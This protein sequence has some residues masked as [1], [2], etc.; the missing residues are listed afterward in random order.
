MESSISGSSRRT[1]LQRTAV[2]LGGAVG[3]AACGQAGTRQAA[4]AATRPPVAPV[5]GT[6]WML[7]GSGRTLVPA[8]VDGVVDPA[9]IAFGGELIDPATG[10]EVGR[11]R[12]QALGRAGFPGQLAGNFEI[13]SL[14]LAGDALYAVGPAGSDR[15]ERSYTVIGG[16]GR[17][18]GARGTCVVREAPGGGARRA[19]QF[20]IS[21]S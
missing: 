13:Q 9:A 1:L 17:F 5:A 10:A 11:F 16:T 19:L 20:D 12:A 8:P 15:T 21:L 4:A 14:Q 18:A 3:V 2:L 7:R 6:A